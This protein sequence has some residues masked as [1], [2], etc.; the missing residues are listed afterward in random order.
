MR[1]IARVP[2][3][4]SYAHVLAAENRANRLLVLTGGELSE[5]AGAAAVAAGLLPSEGDEG[6]A[7]AQTV[8]LG[9]DKIPNS[10]A[11]RQL[12]LGG[13]RH[14]LIAS[15]LGTGRKARRVNLCRRTVAV[16]VRP[17]VFPCH[18]GLDARLEALRWG[19]GRTRLT[20]ITLSP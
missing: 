4:H 1:E 14:R 6:K 8:R 18:Q 13:D 11:L 9:S 5:A 17:D 12:G 16:G 15:L 7:A 3:L 2:G 10:D 20:D 19:E